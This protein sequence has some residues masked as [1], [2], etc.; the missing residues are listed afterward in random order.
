MI[1]GC[2]LLHDLKKSICEK[3][4]IVWFIFL[5]SIMT[6]PLLVTSVENCLMAIPWKF[7]KVLQHSSVT[8]V[9]TW[10]FVPRFYSISSPCQDFLL[11]LLLY[12]TI[13]SFFH[14][15]TNSFHDNNQYITYIAYYLIYYTTRYTN[16]QP[17]M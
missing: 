1:F 4:A 2:H 8:L 7:R 14:V 6:R 12:I 10:R 3:T 15:Q 5:Q 17:V 11:L 13:K 16:S 9:C